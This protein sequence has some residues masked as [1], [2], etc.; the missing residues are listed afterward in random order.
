M[1]I[2]SALI[3]FT[4]TSKIAVQYASKIATREKAT[5]NLLHITSNG[6]EQE[7]ETKRKLI[8]FTEIEKL[9]IPFSVSLGSGHYLKKIPKLLQLSDSDFVVIGTHGTK[10]IFQTLFGSNV[11]NLV[12][13]LTIPALVVQDNT[14]VPPLPIKKILFPLAP[15]SDFKIKVEHTA[16]WAKLFDA[17]VDVFCLFKGDDTL[18]EN[19]AIN[20]EL[21]KDMFD[22]LGVKYKTTLKDSQVYSI[23]YAKDIIAYTEDKDFNLLAIMSQNSEENMYFGNV[24]KTNL[25][26][27]PK[28]IPVLCITE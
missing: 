20:L 2:I 12:Q 9:N 1:K 11:L 22:E 17:E 18:P 13:H 24:D 4:E 19:I 5:V 25:I 14:P 26:L 3:D 21:T 8:E 27:N 28:G 16:R 6:D 10:G 15:H 7:E 23:G